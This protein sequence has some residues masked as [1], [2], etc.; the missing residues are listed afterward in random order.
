[1]R[2]GALEAHRS[3]FRANDDAVAFRVRD[4]GVLVADAVG[5]LRPDAARRVPTGM[6]TTL[7]RVRGGVDGFL[8]ALAEQADRAR[9]L[10]AIAFALALVLGVAAVLV[11]D[12][13]RASAFRLG[14]AAA[15]AGGLVALLV[16]IAPRVLAAGLD[17]GDRA[18]VTAA[19]GVWL[20]PVAH[21]ALAVAAIGACVAL[22]AVT[23]VRPIPVAAALGRVRAAVA[24]PPRNGR[25]RALRLAAALAAGAVMLAWP[26]T[27]VSAVVV[28]AGA[29]LVIVAAAQLLALAAGPAGSAAPARPRPSLGRAAR[30]AAAVLA[31]SAVIVGV[32]IAAGD[33][34]DIPRTGRCNGHAALCDRRLDEVALLGTHNSMAAAG[35]RGWLFAAQ[36]AGIP[37]QLRAGVRALLIDTHYGVRTPR[38]VLTDLEGENA[39]RQKLVAEVGERVVATAERIRRRIGRNPAGARDVFLCHTLCEVGATRTFDALRQVHRFLVRNPEEVLVLS[40]Q[41]DTSA[42]DTARMIRS[43][44]LVDEVYRGRAGR[45][46]PTLREMIDRDERVVVLAEKR[47]GGAPWIHHQPAVMQETPFHFRTAAELAAAASCDPNRGGTAGSLFLVN[48]W[49]DTSPAPRVTIARQVNARAF[50]E[51]RLARCRAARGKLPTVVAVDFFR[52]GDPA[53]VVD[54]LNGVR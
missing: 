49:V 3:A 52:Q 9:R 4:A 39:T 51:P 5:A 15:G 44:G 37:A 50:L 45:P 1:V 13:R 24:R 48:H 6:V 40:I 54:G 22:A 11:T 20:D 7:A 46:W 43:S 29:A 38:G 33:G 10:A 18:A 26:R 32:A 30:V 31:G 47:A 36:D 25:E 41:D 23:V 16:W 2:R 28:V 53:A 21:W 42:A 12:S 19:A 17:A 14:V 8:L 34:A 27:V 35:E